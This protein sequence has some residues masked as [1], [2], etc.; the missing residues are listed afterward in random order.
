MKRV[1]PQMIA[2][3][4]LFAGSNPLVLTGCNEKTKNKP[5]PITSGAGTEA[6]PV[7]GTQANLGGA[8]QAGSQVGQ[9]G[10]AVRTG[11][12]C[13][14]AHAGAGCSDKQIQDCVCGYDPKCCSNA[15]D[16]VC[17]EYL[18]IYGCGVCPGDCCSATNLPGCGDNTKVEKCVC[19]WNSDCCTKW[20]TF[21]VDINVAKCG[22]VCN[23]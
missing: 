17:V 2:S 16:F 4:L 10:S 8:G 13:C 11:S 20:D 14:A 6:N 15:W 12:T 1:I 7:A 19:T 23:E 21:C 22:G 9:S 5:V 3:L 18:K